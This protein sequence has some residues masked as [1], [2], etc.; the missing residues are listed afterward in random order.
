MD[1][2][3]LGRDEQLSGDLP[4]A[5]ADREQPQDLDL[6]L[7]QSGQ[8]VTCCRAGEAGL[9]PARGRLRSRPV[10]QACPPGQVGQGGPQWPGADALCYLGGRQQ[11]TLG[12][13]AAA[14]RQRDRAVS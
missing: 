5:V 2:G 1:A 3:G 13:I 10:S 14:S 7:G 4:V 8:R 12:L 11:L 9:T 6:P